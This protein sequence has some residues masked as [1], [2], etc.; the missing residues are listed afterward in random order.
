MY[1]KTSSG[2]KRNNVSGYTR[3]LGISAIIFIT[4]FAFLC[5]GCKS[6]ESQSEKKLIVVSYGGGAYQTSHKVSFCEPFSLYTGISVTS[7]TWNA[8]YGKLKAMVESGKVPWDV[9]E[10]TAAQF[11]RGLSDNLFSRLIVKPTDG[12]FL[13][14][15]ISDY[16]VAN[17]YWG[18]VLAYNKEEFSQSPPQNWADFFDT[19]KY[20]GDRA[21]YD[22][23][24]GNLEFALLADGVPL[25]KLYP[26]D[27]D[28]AFKKLDTIKDAIRVWY[29]DGSQP[30][31]LLLTRTVKIS[32]VW[33]GR[34]FASKEANEKIG[35]SWHGAALEL[36]Y[37]I[38]PKGT[39]NVDIAS[40][41]IA[42]SSSPYAMAKQ[43]EFV[44]YGP[45]NKS[46]LNYVKE[47]IRVQL[48]T[49][50][51]NFSV[52]FVV[53]ADWWSENEQTLRTRWL[54]W[55]NQ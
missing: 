4:A 25:E 47:D 15:T 49:Y 55:K 5:S 48:P 43:I 21:L 16:G 40:R 17:V 26:I 32:S 13:P 33:N 9:V 39:K 36:D 28:R 3:M 51:P 45:V 6:N 19:K 12:D 27:V 23:P 8:E 34:I 44:G 7:V 11:S 54:A 46:S 42:Y 20:P 14:N 1:L 53:N 30:L 2:F 52:S 18:T 29:S 41:F 50:E 22:D 37:W 38:V 10:V 31:Q 24:R 35:Y